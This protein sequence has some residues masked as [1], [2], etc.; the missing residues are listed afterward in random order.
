MKKFYSVN[1]DL[2]IHI[3]DI[4]SM[5]NGNSAIGYIIPPNY[6]EYERINKH[7]FQPLR[8]QDILTENTFDVVFIQK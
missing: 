8:K 3:N 1:Q 7:A 5:E 6:T 2:Y 4:E